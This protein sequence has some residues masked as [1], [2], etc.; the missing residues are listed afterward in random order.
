VNGTG[1]Y[2]FST[3]VTGNVSLGYGQNQDRQRG[4]KR[5]NVRIELRA[6]FTF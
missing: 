1:S 4:I 6:Q 5:R 2:A 3:N